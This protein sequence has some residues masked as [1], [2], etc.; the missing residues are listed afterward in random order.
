M[1]QRIEKLKEAIHSTALGLVVNGYK[2]EKVLSI[3]LR[4]H[5]PE[6]MDISCVDKWKRVSACLQARVC[7]VVDNISKPTSINATFS[8][9]YNSDDDIFIIKDTI[10][11]IV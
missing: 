11:S 2:V 1:Y 4:H 3:D 6:E 8:I 10:L 7:N 9:E 5:I